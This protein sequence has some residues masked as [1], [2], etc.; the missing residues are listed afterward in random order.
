MSFK[1]YRWSKDYEAAEE[2]L[3]KLLARL[4]H[5]LNRWEL[6][7]GERLPLQQRQNPRRLW[8]AEGSVTLVIAGKSIG[9]QPGDAITI[10]PSQSVAGVAGVAG[11]VCYE[12]TETK[13][14]VTSD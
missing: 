13:S 7:A 10:D 9:L 3:E 2:E 5:D 11:V 12:A 1:K 6:A 4:G 8:C 14:L